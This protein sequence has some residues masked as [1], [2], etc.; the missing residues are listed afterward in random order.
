MPRRAYAV[1]AAAVVVQ[2]CL[3]ATYAWSVFVQALRAD[4][5][6][7]QGSAQIP[8]TVFYIAFPATTVVAGRLLNRVG[9]RRLAALGGLVFSLGWILAG[10]GS[11]HFAFTI[12]GIGALSGI[13][14]GFAYLVPIAVGMRWFPQRKGLVTGFAVVGFGGGAALVSQ[15]GVYLMGV[16]GCTPFETFRLLGAVFLLLT[17]PAGSFLQYPPGAAGRTTAAFAR[18][19][20]LRERDF[21]FLYLAM[22]T[23]LAA[24]FTVNANLGQLNPRVGTTACGFALASF[25]AVANALGRLAWG[26][27]F[28]RVPS[29]TAIR[30]NL[31]AQAMLFVLHPWLLR[32]PLGLAAFAWVAGFNYGGVLV[33]YAS[34]VGRRWGAEHVGSIYGWLFSSNMPAAVAPL[35]AGVAFGAFGTFAPALFTL[36]ALL[37]AA[38]AWVRINR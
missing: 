29:R 21:W 33:L 11:R 26:L 24:G 28:D 18:P 4:G 25:F 35:L 36:A 13:G 14:V 8:F 32:S 31:L 23:G 38:A 2:V 9:P 12:I 5:A 17:V 3:G 7:G 20:A 27:I 22:F 16:H 10:F 15:A 6:L 37:V 30:A 34:S 1:L 19:A